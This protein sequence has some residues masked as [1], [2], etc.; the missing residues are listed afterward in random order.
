MSP[1]RSSRRS[2]SGTVAGVAGGTPQPSAYGT[3]N[4]PGTVPVCRITQ[5]VERAIALAA[6]VPRARWS[7]VCGF[8][9]GDFQKKDGRS[10][11]L[12]RTAAPSVVILVPLA[13]TPTAS[14]NSMLF[15]DTSGPFSGGTN[16]GGTGGAGGGAAA[17]ACGC[18]GAG[19]GRAPWPEAWAAR[20]TAGIS[21]P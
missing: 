19:G 20:A 7:G 16:A 9:G 18:G 21:W 15:P 5:P 14:G 8:V 4:S 17:G 3:G 6:P 2:R 10:A 11:V 12:L 1:L 13:L